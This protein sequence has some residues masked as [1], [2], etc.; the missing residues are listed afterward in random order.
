MTCGEASDYN[1]VPGLLAIPVYKPRLFIAD[2][3]YD[4]DFLREE[5]LIHGIRP[6]IPRK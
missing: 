4:G 6:V 2:K 3:G 1:A 5:L